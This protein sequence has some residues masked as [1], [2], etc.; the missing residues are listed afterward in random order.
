[1]ANLNRPRIVTVLG[2][3]PELIKCSTLLPRFDDLFEH[4]L[5]HTGQHYDEQ[6]DAVFFRDLGLRAPDYALHVGSGSHA[7]QLAGMLTGIEAALLERRP[8]LVF[9]QGDTNS[10]LAGGLAAAKLN[11][12]VAHLEAGCRSF[13]RAMPEE[14][15][16]VVVDHLA[17][18]LLAPDDLAA[19]NLRR[20]GIAAERVSIVGSTGIDACLRM[21]Q[22]PAGGETLRALGVEPR[23]YLVATIHRAENTTPER[24]A[25]IMAA[26]ADLSTTWPIIFPV[27]PRTAKSLEGI[28]CSA[29][30]RRIEPVGYA[31]MIQLLGGCR[32]LLT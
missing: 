30:V 29:D 25:G 26:L 20:E 16:R 2:T 7:S 18:L 24:L 9:V 6:M 31:T 21:A 22:S 1:M 3:R 27:H 8:D 13:N 32:A 15:N 28:A 23:G 10:T 14:T 12:P 19:D 17:D 4:A 11:M 5:V